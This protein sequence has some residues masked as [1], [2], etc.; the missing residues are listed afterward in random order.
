[1]LSLRLGLALGVACCASAAD[2]WTEYYFPKASG[3][4][5]ASKELMLVTTADMDAGQTLAIA[6][7]QGVAAQTK[8]LL[9]LRFAND[10]AGNSLGLWA[11]ELAAYWGVAFRNESN[12]TA[13]MQHARANGYAGSFVRVTA[14]NDSAGVGLMQCAMQASATA[15][16]RIDPSAPPCVVCAD[17]ACDTLQ[18]LGYTQFLDS[19]EATYDSFYAGLRSMS[20]FRPRVSMLQNPAAWPNLA[21]YAAFCRCPVYFEASMKQVAPVVT[22]IWN[23][24]ASE[25]LGGVTMGYG[26]DE[27][28]TVI[29]LS[30]NSNGMVASDDAMNLATL[31]NYAMPPLNE[32]T[33]EGGKEPFEHLRTDDDPRHVVTFLMSDGDNIQWMVNN[34]ASSTNWYASPNRGKVP[35]GWTLATSLRQLAAPAYHYIKRTQTPNDTFVGSVSGNFYTFM[36]NMAPSWVG[37]FTENSTSVLKANGMNVVNVMGNSDDIGVAVESAVPYFRAG[38]K[39]VLYYPY[40]SYCDLH[41][42]NGYMSTDEYEGWLLGARYCLWSAQF[43]VTQM[44]DALNKQ[45]MD[46][47]SDAGYSVIPVIVWSHTYDDVMAV[48]DGLDKNRTRVVSMDEY[49]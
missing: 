28:D 48:V 35:V 13:V 20:P 27:I 44:I 23:Y 30:Q 41:G 25:G 9:L 1:M 14:G 22:R 29:A 17:A 43:N 38:M 45:A 33:E 12:F 8:P 49:C 32:S 11:S 19:R 6:S 37:P 47:S 40:A 42:Q 21:D 15:S 5:N 3:G 46:P 34:F 7:L 26:P 24:T 16:H 18:S 39:Y 4:F 36:D 10:S 2:E 31:T